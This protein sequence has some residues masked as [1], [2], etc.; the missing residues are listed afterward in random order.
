MSD[1]FAMYLCVYLS[2]CVC[3]YECAVLVLACLM[4]ESSLEPTL[5]M[6]LDWLFRGDSASQRL[7]RFDLPES[8]TPKISPRLADERWVSAGFGKEL[9]KLLAFPDEV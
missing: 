5:R 4:R 3:V 1:P 8:V 7:S 2:L 9:A 6:L